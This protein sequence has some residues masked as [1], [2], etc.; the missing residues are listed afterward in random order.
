MDESEAH[1]TQFRHKI[2]EELLIRALFK[3]GDESCDEHSDIATNAK[4]GKTV[5]HISI[6]LIAIP[7]KL[8]RCIR[9]C[10]NQFG[11]KI[12]SVLDQQS[13]QQ[14]LVKFNLA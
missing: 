9:R 14:W 13:L 3:F 10:R 6:S 1:V 8:R 12:R 11:K 4:E 5:N 2:E 7:Y